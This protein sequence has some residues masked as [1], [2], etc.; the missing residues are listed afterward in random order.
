MAAKAIAKTKKKTRRGP[1][2]GSGA[3]GAQGGAVKWV[4]QPIRRKEENRLVSGKGIFVDDEKMPGMLHIRFVRSSYAH[5]RIA[6]VDV[7]KA[8]KFPGVVC[9]LTGAEIKR[10]VQPFIEIGPGGAQK[11]ADYPM[12]VD[13]VVFQGE[14]V[15]A[16]V[17]ETRLAAED[18]AELVEVDY[19]PLPPVV[20]AED[21]L[22]DESLLHPAMGTNRN[23]HG[24]FEYG[25]VEKAFK[26][27][28]HVVHIGRLHF[29]R[30]SSTPLECNVI[31]AN[32]DPRSGD[33]EYHCNNTFPSFASQFLAPALGV[34]IDQIHMKSFDIG[35]GFG[36]KI[37]SYPYM[38]VCA[39]ASRKAGGRAVK[40]VEARIEHMQASAHGNERTF[41]DTRVAL[42]KTGV[43][44][45]IDSKHV[46]DCGAFPRNSRR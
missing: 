17:A 24:V 29:H 13:K 9:T 41:L 19:E 38:A 35:G 37:T 28:A 46:D 26:Q 10:Q 40:W 45:A 7:S 12:A 5:A 3:D 22:K 16:V 11:I 36:I 33:I 15:A 43:I 31:L 27:A 18:A 42:D 14:P 21:A 34:R 20:T 8:E 44:L 30:F 2:T 1:R 32:W 6:R 39:L 4:G 23:W 25:D